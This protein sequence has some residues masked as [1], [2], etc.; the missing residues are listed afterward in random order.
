MALDSS[1]DAEGTVGALTLDIDL[2]FLSTAFLSV[3]LMSWAPSSYFFTIL[4]SA[5]IYFTAKMSK[6]STAI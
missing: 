4:P 1:H 3:E 2:P 6:E 5:E